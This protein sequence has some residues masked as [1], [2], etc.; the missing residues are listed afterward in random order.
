[1]QMYH[2]GV[3][4]F[5]I[6]RLRTKVRDAK[7]QVLKIDRS[8]SAIKKCWACIVSSLMLWVCTFHR[9]ISCLSSCGLWM[10]QISPW[11]NLRQ[12]FMNIWSFLTRPG[13]KHDEKISNCSST[14]SWSNLTIL[15]WVS[16]FFNFSHDKTPNLMVF[17]W[18]IILKWNASLF[19]KNENVYCCWIV[20][21][22]HDINAGYCKLY[23]AVSKR[24]R[25]GFAR[26]LSAICSSNATK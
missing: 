3:D 17:Q 12:K 19:N 24:L 5:V 25:D 14:P 6:S 13:D 7:R 4:T 9:T 16:R 2:S 11:P 20:T 8:R 21:D 26:H 1:M 15:P 22:P 18:N 10:F 23:N